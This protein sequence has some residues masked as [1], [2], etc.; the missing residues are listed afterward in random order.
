M[1]CAAELKVQSQN[2]REK[3]AEAKEIVYK[4]GFYEGVFLVPGYEG[5]NAFD[6]VLIY[7]L[8]NHGFFSFRC[9]CAG[10]EGSDSPDDD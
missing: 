10:G 3:L 1:W 8:R 7:P 4:K 5:T 2:D 9:A 6:F